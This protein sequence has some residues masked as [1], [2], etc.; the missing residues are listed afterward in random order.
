MRGVN[1]QLRVWLC[2]NVLGPLLLW[3]F[4]TDLTLRAEGTIVCHADFDKYMPLF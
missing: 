1:R 4:D 2:G 3:W